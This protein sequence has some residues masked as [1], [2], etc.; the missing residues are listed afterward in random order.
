[1]K[2]K[3]ELNFT[4]KMFLMGLMPEEDSF[5]NLVI[6]ED[7]IDKIKPSQSDYE[8]N[9]FSSVGQQSQW[10]DNGKVND[11]ELTNP[12]LEYFKV[13]LQEADQ[14]KTLNVKLINVYKQIV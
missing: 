13:K 7:I 8:D 1:M 10:D 12:E 4:E 6:R 5:S 2:N 9:K 14:K 11:Y 3:L